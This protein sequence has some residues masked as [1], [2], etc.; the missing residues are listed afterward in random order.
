MNNLSDDRVNFHAVSSVDVTGARIRPRL[1]DAPAV[2]PDLADV[3]EFVWR[4]V[5]KAAVE[6]ARTGDVESRRFAMGSLRHLVRLR[7]WLDGETIGSSVAEAHLRRLADVHRKQSD[8][9]PD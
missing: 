8:C 2:D 1:V 4:R 6:A 7:H 5:E 3:F 9:F